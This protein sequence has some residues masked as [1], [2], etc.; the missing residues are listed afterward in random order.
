MAVFFSVML[1]KYVLNH[2]AGFLRIKPDGSLKIS[3]LLSHNF[4][5]TSIEEGY[6]ENKCLSLKSTSISRIGFSKEPHVTELQRTFKLI[7]D[8]MLLQTVFMA[9]TKKHVLEILWL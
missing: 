9:T 1:I 3:L 6:L 7:D 8:N 5:L 4:G 2:F